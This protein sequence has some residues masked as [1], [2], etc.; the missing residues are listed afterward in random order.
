MDYLGLFG[1]LRGLSG[2]IWGFARVIS[3]VIRGFGAGYLGLFP[4]N[5]WKFLGN[6]DDNNRVGDTARV[7]VCGFFWSYFGVFGFHLGK[8][9]GFL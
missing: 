4:P 6:H 1:D 8:S 2:V 3:G 5:S 7:R 9:L